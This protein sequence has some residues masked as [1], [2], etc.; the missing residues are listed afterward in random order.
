M[1]KEVQIMLTLSSFIMGG[2]IAAVGRMADYQIIY[3]A[4]GWYEKN[5]LI[6]TDLA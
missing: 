2:L 4:V 5:L 6:E 1:Y 3:N